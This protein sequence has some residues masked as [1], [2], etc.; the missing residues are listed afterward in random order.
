MFYFWRIE[1]DDDE[2]RILRPRRF[3]PPWTV[4]DLGSCF[5]VKDGAGQKLGHFYYEEKP[6]RRS[7]AKMLTR[8]EA[9]RI[10]A[11]VTK[12][13]ELLRR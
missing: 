1:S 9:R 3:P 7:E 8:D 2:W 13:P 6:G 4:E 5:V 10:A 12:L 11:S